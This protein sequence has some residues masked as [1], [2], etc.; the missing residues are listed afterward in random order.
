MD[1]NT[2]R[3][4]LVKVFDIDNDV[5]SARMATVFCLG[6]SALLWWIPVFGPAVAGYVCGRKTGSMAKGIVCSMVSGAILLLLVMGLSAL[7]L[8]HGGYPGVPANEAAASLNGIVGATAAYL[9]TF[10]VEGTADL[11]LMS[12]G[13]VTVFG[14]VGGM[15][16]R[17]V[18]K[19]TAHLIAMGA[20]EGTSRPTARSVRLYGANKEM[21]FHSFEDCIAAQRMATNEN[22]DSGAAPKEAR[23]ERA[24][25]KPVATTVQTVTTTVSGNTA[26]TQSKGSWGPFSDILDRADRKKDDK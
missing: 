5:Y 14:G 26:P 9:Q 8:G 20:T 25:D 6:L 10:F 21:G 3:Q 13:V 2:L 1:G 24:K 19:E 18:R 23:E 17:Q 22:K 11:N 7:V 15:L 4:S 12:L 16:S